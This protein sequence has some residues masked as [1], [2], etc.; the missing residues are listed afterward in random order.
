MRTESEVELRERT[1]DVKTLECLSSESVSPHL[2]ELA[3]KG[4]GNDKLSIVLNDNGEEFPGEAERGEFIRNYYSMLYKRDHWVEGSIEDFLGDHICSHPTVVASKLSVAEMDSLDSPL[5]LDELDQALKK[6][7]IRSAPGIDGFSYRFIQAFWGTYRLP[8]FHAARDGLENG[9]LPGSFM[10]AKIK[11]IPKKGDC[12]KIK[13]WRPISLLSNFYKIISRL[14]NTRLQ[15]V[16]D[17]LLTG[18][19]GLYKI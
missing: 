18:T 13:N 1:R 10:V 4:D 14:I 2:L 19:K 15:R 3:K 16:V 8:L 6:A 17:R 11:L 5:V 9:T 12:T 7:N